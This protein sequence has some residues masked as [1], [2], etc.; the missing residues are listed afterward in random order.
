M[1]K[2]ERQALLGALALSKKAGALV[3]GFD[4]VAKCL[5]RG[6]VKLLLWATDLSPGTKKKLMQAAGPGQKA[7]EL[8]FTQGELAPICGKPVGV[9]AL[10]D[11][12][13]VKLCLSKWQ[14]ERRIDTV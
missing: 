14:E 10:T 3:L 9:L 7:R 6:Q 13:L 2:N 5:S 11:E 1:D 8:P 12:N 4:A